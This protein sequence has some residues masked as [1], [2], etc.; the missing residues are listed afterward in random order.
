MSQAGAAGVKFISHNI[1]YHL[2]TQIESL[3]EGETVANGACWAALDCV[4]QPVFYTRNLLPLDFRVLVF[5][6]NTLQSYLK[7]LPIAQNEPRCMRLW[8][9]SLARRPF[10]P[11]LLCQHLGAKRCD[12]STQ[13]GVNWPVCQTCPFQSFFLNFGHANK[14]FP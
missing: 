1:V 8:S 14:Y 5:S 7:L 3:I 13:E 10:N 4:D 2:M 6:T 9:K 11:P 12:S